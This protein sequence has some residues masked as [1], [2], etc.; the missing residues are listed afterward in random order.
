MFQIFHIFKTA[1][2]R[3]FAKAIQNITGIAPKNLRLYETALTHSSVRNTNQGTDNERLEYLGDAVLDLVAADILFKQFPYEAEGS[4]TEMRARF[5]NATFLA[6]AAYKMG[7]E[8]MLKFDLRNK[9]LLHRQKNVHADALEALIG[10]IY[11]DQGFGVAS[12]FIKERIVKLYVD[13]SQL[14][15]VITNHKSKVIE[16]AQRENKSIDF[17]VLEMIQGE[18]GKKQFVIALNING[19]TVAKGIDYT[20]KQA[21]QLAAAQFFTSI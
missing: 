3:L 20:K 8:K 21:E 17:E 12:F 7:I 16:W 9:S 5:V 6:D 2:Q 4:L 14:K 19:E 11:L 18:H 1:E 10:A 15:D 13:F